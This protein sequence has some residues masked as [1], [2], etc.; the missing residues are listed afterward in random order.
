MPFSDSCFSVFKERCWS[1]VCQ[2]L[3]IREYLACWSSVQFFLPLLALALQPDLLVAEISEEN[4]KLY[5]KI[6]DLQFGSVSRLSNSQPSPQA[7]FTFG[8]VCLLSSAFLQA[9]GIK[10]VQK[11]P[12]AYETTC[13]FC[14]LLCWESQQAGWSRSVNNIPVADSLSQVGFPWP[15][16]LLKKKHKEGL[17]PWLQ[18]S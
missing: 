1:Q 2:S 5:F 9:S 8:A 10:L 6:L 3:A 11:K 12:K 13:V 17:M 15:P 4:S 14:F 7:A 16:S 18:D